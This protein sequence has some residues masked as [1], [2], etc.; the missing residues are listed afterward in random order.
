MARPTIFNMNLGKTG[1]KI[2]SVTS[3]AT[4][5]LFT[6]ATKGEKA[7]TKEFVMQIVRDGLKV[8]GASGLG[9]ALASGEQ[10]GILASAASILVGVIWGFVA[11]KDANAAK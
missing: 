6:L 4:S 1:E 3:L 7:M 2:Q 8:F 9:L 10:W 5:I 11:R